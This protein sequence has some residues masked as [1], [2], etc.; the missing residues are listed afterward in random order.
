MPTDVHCFVMSSTE[1][2]VS[3]QKGEYKT[4]PTN[5]S[6][7]A[8]DDKNNATKFSCSTEGKPVYCRF[9]VGFVLFNL[10]FS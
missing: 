5:Y 2:K 8:I 6:V 7:S 1:I 10:Q 9:L 3:W 4:G